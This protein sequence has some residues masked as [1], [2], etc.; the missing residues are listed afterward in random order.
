M[1]VVVRSVLLR[2]LA[3]VQHPWWGAGLSCA[4]LLVCPSQ[5]G[6]GEHDAPVG[7]DVTCAAAQG[8]RRETGWEQAAPGFLPSSPGLRTQQP[9]AVK[10][11]TSGTNSCVGSKVSAPGQPVGQPALCSNVSLPTPA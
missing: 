7:T 2:V 11:G 9:P 4:R 5:S 1:C 6:D 8:G 10:L 3:G